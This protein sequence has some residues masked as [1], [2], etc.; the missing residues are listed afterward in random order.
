MKANDIINNSKR[1]HK[2]SIS[3]NVSIV[4]GL[5][6]LTISGSS[7]AMTYEF[8]EVEPRTIVGGRW[9]QSKREMFF[10]SESGSGGGSGGGGPGGPLSAPTTA[11]PAPP[12][13]SPATAPPPPPTA[14]TTSTTTTTQPASV[15]S[16]KE[17][18]LT[19]KER[20]D[21]KDEENK[22]NK[23]VKEL[24]KERRPREVDGYVGFANLPNQVYRKAVKRGF[25]FSLMVVDCPDI[26]QSVEPARH[27]TSQNGFGNLVN[28]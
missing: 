7:E 12:V 6:S 10:K 20:K 27:L 1:F 21:H 28:H 3:A 18:L 11:P 19:P 23:L 5:P 4:R 13:T 16:I 14:T 25:E 17:Q 15:A 2:I 26:S 24:V 8:G 22:E 9:L